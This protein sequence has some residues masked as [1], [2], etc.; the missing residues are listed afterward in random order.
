[1]KLSSVLLCVFLLSALA[2]SSEGRRRSAGRRRLGLISTIGWIGND[3]RKSHTVC[4]GICERKS[5]DSFG[6]VQCHKDYHCMQRCKNG[7]SCAPI[8]DELEDFEDDEDV[9]D[10]AYTTGSWRRRLW[11]NPCP[12][13]NPWCAAAGLIINDITN[14]PASCT[15]L[16]ERPIKNY[17]TVQCHQDYKCMQEC[18]RGG[19]CMIWN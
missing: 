7:G 14:T 13:S 16:C 3:I 17:G 19:S 9:D 5:E 11:G 15:G 4:G 18:N 1:M 2:I 8:N 12:K 10:G 6:N